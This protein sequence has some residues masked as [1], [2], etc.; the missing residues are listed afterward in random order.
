MNG[1]KTASLKE[2]ISSLAIE[3]TN[4]LDP[5]GY[6]DKTYLHGKSKGKPK[7]YWNIDGHK[8]EQLWKL[9][10]PY[11]AKSVSHSGY[12]AIDNLEKEDF[13][14]DIK[15]W[16]YKVMFNFGPQPNGK[17]FHEQIP[18]TVNNALTNYWRRQ[19]QPG[20]RV[21]YESISLAF[22][23]TDGF[24]IADTLEAPED[25]SVEI[26]LGH[27]NVH[28][29]A[30]VRYYLQCESKT[31]T[32]KRFGVTSYRLQKLLQSCLS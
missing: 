6:Q 8:F 1:S 17:P 23:L 18:L 7:P 9:I 4:G 31:E 15:I 24:S 5:A 20:K 21:N 11:V 32:R 12:Y 29:Q 27:L 14:E 2:Q 13:I 28:E 16:F 25:F 10:Y 19:Q 22:Q 30:I 26:L 3:V